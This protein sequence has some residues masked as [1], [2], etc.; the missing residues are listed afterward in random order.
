VTAGGLSRTTAQLDLSDGQNYHIK[1]TSALIEVITF[2]QPNRCC[3]VVLNRRNKHRLVERLSNGFINSPGIRSAGVAPTLVAT[4]TAT[5]RLN[6]R[7]TSKR[8]SIPKAGR[9]T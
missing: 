4:G 1:V 5:H 6:R 9:H 3:R 2:T 8:L 7:T